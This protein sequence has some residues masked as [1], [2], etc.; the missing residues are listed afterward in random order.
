MKKVISLC[1]LTLFLCVGMQSLNA[2]EKFKQL[3]E[4]AKIQSQELQKLL[5]LDENQTAMVWRT[6]YS[7][8]RMY[9]E[10]ITNKDLNDPKIAG[11]KK[12]IDA[13]FKSKMTQILNDEQFALFREWLKDQQ[14]NE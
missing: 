11:M 3:D 5:G 6:L 13:N 4:R 14:K 9:A 2:Q 10:N 8:D 1:F 7:N 12:K